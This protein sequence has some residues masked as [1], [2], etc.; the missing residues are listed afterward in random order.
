MAE[1][2]DLDIY[3]QR[4]DAAL[5]DKAWWLSYIDDSIDTV[6]DFG[7]AT[8]RLQ[9]MIESIAPGKYRYI[10]IDNAYE[11][12]R[13]FVADGEIYASF[14]EAIGHFNPA[15]SVLVFNS[16][17]HEI[18]TYSSKS[19]ILSFQ[20]I[21][22]TVPFAY[23]AIRDMYQKNNINFPDG[24]N[25]LQAIQNSPYAAQFNEFKALSRHTKPYVLAKEFF[26]K[27]R[28]K[29]NWDREKKE[30]YLWDWKKYLQNL[31][32]NVTIAYEEDFYI[33]FVAHKI[34]EDFHINYSETTH[35]KM[36]FYNK[37]H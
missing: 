25:Y 30:Q 20:H 13:N 22:T 26:L 6:V 19:E 23:I 31:L 14:Q 24:E 8:G 36:L 18:F 21:L 33:P 9:H 15:T 12:R 35:K 28:Y 3:I 4:M 29:E 5:P 2:K 17:L 16:V 32:K 34:E 1:I 11:M 37:H 27:Y 10:G 7:C